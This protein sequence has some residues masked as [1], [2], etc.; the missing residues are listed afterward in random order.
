MASIELRGIR[1]LY[2][3]V[4][5]VGRLDLPIRDGEFLVL[6]GPSGCGKTTILRTIAGLEEP[7]EGTVL[8][9]GRD[10]TAVPP[11]DRD[12]AMV[13]QSYALYPHMT[14][15]ENLEFGL[16][17]RRVPPDEAASRVAD[18][19]RMLG[20]DALL[21]R[22]PRQLSGGQRQ[23]VAM[24]RAMV[25]RPRAFL[26]DEPLS[27]LDAALRSQ[28][29]VE[30]RR[31]HRELGTTMVYVTHDQ[32]EAM[33]LADRLALFDR[34]A[35]QQIGT[36]D[37]LFDRPANV[38]VGSFIGSPAMNILD[39]AVAGESGAPAVR[40]PGFLAPLLPGASPR[41][42][43][44]SAVRLGVRPHDLR[45]QPELGHDDPGFRCAVEA[46][47]PLGSEVHLHARGEFGRITAQIDRTALPRP[48]DPGDTILLAADPA[49][50]HLFDTAGA[51]IGP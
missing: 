10:V 47:E 22:Y 15:R 16:R 49:R 32:V 8:I 27:N 31:L 43:P 42:D 11:R 34:G 25:R 14:A 24:G 12:V 44:G 7:T 50:M 35:L 41:L 4:E 23:R 1:K 6:V 45:P 19:S 48:L 13:F 20:I 46:I 30:I 38:F 17:A 33:T 39:G 51:R 21:D 36:P 5:V 18:V 40:G 3:S 28:V 9:D 37:D 29:R 26:L 2:G